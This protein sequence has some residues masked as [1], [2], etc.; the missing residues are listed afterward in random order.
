MDD[1]IISTALTC[2]DRSVHICCFSLSLSLSTGIVVAGVPCQLTIASEQIVF[3]YSDSLRSRI[4][5]APD[6][7]TIR[8]ARNGTIHVDWEDA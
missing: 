3:H 7:H 5:G 8:E 1:N 6:Q 2:H 4:K